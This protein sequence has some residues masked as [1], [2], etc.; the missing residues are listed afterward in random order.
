MLPPSDVPSPTAN[1]RR[2]PA[3]TTL[4]LDPARPRRDASDRVP[5]L[6]RAGSAVTLRRR[7]DPAPRPKERSPSR[8]AKKRSEPRKVSTPT[9]FE[10]ARDELFSHIL[11]C[12]VLEAGPDHQKEWFADTILYLTDRERDAEPA[13]RARA[14]L[15]RRAQQELCGGRESHPGSP[16]VGPARRPER[17]PRQTRAEAAADPQLHT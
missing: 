13:V 3:F 17:E 16:L 5:P 8:M 15:S 6:R 4:K 7:S 10:Q 11:R 1:P 2:R 14:A 12:G 9:P